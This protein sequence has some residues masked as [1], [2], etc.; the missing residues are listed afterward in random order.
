MAA[1][2]FVYLL[3]S[4]RTGEPYTG[5]TTD[6]ARRLAEHNAGQ[7]PS[8]VRARPWELVVLIE[9]TR[10]ATAVQ[11]ERYLKTGSGRAFAQRHLEG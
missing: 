2:N 9:F 5:L 6:F 4:T 8:T 1:K 7:N 11:F 10:E 3:R